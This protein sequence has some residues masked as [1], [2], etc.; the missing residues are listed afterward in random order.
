[1]VL[2]SLMPRTY[3]SVAR[4]QGFGFDEGQSFPSRS[5][6]PLAIALDAALKRR[7]RAIRADEALPAVS[8]RQLERLAVATPDTECEVTGVGADLLLSCHLWFLLPYQA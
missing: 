7:E 4:S 5:G 6:H 8:L 2:L 3:S 1:M